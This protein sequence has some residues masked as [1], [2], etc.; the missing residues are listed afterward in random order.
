MNYI[1]VT[2]VVAA[3]GLLMVGLGIMLRRAAGTY[4]K[5][6]GERIV[7][8]PETHEAAAV[9]VAAGD[10]A[11]KATVGREE[12]ALKECSRWPE[13]EKCGQWCLAEIEEAPKACLV[14]T[15]VQRWYEGK[16]CAYCHKPFGELHWDSH[17][18]A[19]VDAELKTVQWNEIPA[20]KLQET[21][22]THLPVCWDCHIAETFRRE[23]PEMVVDRREDPLRM[24]VYK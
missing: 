2:A 1:S 10:A 9:R 7:S 12:L 6:R 5:F 23:H 11:L 15:I 20:E 14:S 16:E 19:L 21:M 13:R 4:L 24:S 17:K 18:P 3:N 22:R 8:C